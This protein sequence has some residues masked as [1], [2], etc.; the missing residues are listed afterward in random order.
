MDPMRLAL[1]CLVVYAVMLVMTRLCGKR[2]VTHANPVDFA[3]ALVVGDLT[4]NVVWGEVAL[5]VFGA[6]VSSLL[7]VHVVLERLNW[8]AAAA[9]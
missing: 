5:P 6:A 1:R 9:R 8:K 7:L 2:L 4:D 3:L